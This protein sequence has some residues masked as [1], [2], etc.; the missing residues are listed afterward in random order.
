MES[1]GE[2]ARRELVLVGAAALR[3]LFCLA[4][5]AAPALLLLWMGK[6]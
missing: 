2:R 1:D 6:P 3:L 4:A 5:A